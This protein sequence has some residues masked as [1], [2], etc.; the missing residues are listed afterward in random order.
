MEQIIFLKRKIPPVVVRTRITFS[1]I[2]YH[3]ERN[4]DGGLHSWNRQDTGI[5]S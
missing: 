4:W 2:E 3:H 5:K 1:Y